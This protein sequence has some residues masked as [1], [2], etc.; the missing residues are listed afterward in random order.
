ML[1]VD[2]RSTLFILFLSCL[3]LLRFVLVSFRAV[4]ARFGSV[5]LVCAPLRFVLVYF[6]QFQYRFHSLRFVW[7]LCF[8]QLRFYYLCTFSFRVLVRIGAFSL[9]SDRLGSFSF[10]LILVLLALIRFV[11]LRVGLDELVG[12]AS[13][14][15]VFDSDVF[16]LLGSLKV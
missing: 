7:N 6:A 1:S 5:R 12:F 11:S 4:F 8:V 3:G 13:G 9:V 2:E 14:A 10:V 15:V 16:Y